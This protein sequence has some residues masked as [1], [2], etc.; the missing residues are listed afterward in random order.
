MKNVLLAVL[1]AVS[2]LTVSASHAA[3]YRWVDRNGNVTY[4]DEPP[5]ADA[6]QV[7]V[8]HLRVA[9]SPVTKRGGHGSGSSVTLYEVPHCD[10]C[11]MVRIY[12]A[13]HHVPYQEVNVAKNAAA[14]QQ[15]RKV[16][17]NLSVP[18]VTVGPK[19]IQGFM[20]SQLSS[21][22]RQAG[23]ISANKGRP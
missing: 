9:Q 23:L 3:V 22:L 21:D 12:L 1:L 19:V 11:Q 5:P 18:T 10:S 17:G 20:P 7:E 2:A 15:L 4:Q 6:A 8:R 14:L 13:R 16:A